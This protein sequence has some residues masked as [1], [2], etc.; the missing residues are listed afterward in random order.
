MGKPL[1]Y[2]LP[3]SINF[4][5]GL[6]VLSFPHYPGSIW[7]TQFPATHPPIFLH[8]IAHTAPETTAL[9]W[10]YNLHSS[11][12]YFLLVCVCV[13]VC[14]FTLAHEHWWEKS[15]CSLPLPRSPGVCVCVCVCV[16]VFS[17]LPMNTGGKSHVALCLYH[18][19]LV[20][21]CVCSH[22]PT[23]SWC[24]CVCVFALAHEH[25][26]EKSCC[27]LPLPRIPQIHL[28][29]V[30]GLSASTPYPSKCFQSHICSSPCLQ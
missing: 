7:T 22:L 11:S 15:C 14:V 5:R 18:G 16:C 1:K 10:C 3:F 26:W 30:L 4:V 2:Q 17:H 29:L 19:L 6:S 21:V 24:V 25:W 8:P 28:G 23:V 13:C 20:C 27:S 9:I 12:S